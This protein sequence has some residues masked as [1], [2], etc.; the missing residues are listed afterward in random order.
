MEAT[1]GE[2]DFVILER[3]RKQRFSSFI[4]TYSNLTSIFKSPD[5]FVTMESTHEGGEA[6]VAVGRAVTIV[7]AS[8]EDCA[9]WEY[10]K[11]TREDCPNHKRS[12]G[13]DRKIVPL[14]DHAVLYH[15]G[16]AARSEATS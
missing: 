11:M 5:V 13:L 14:N 12:G 3:V 4:A 8:I 16:E 2:A 1:Q 15:I 7:D 10:L 6:V 9:A